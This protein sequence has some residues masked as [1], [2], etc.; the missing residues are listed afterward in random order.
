MS[1]AQ[2]FFLVITIAAPLWY[3]GFALH[4]LAEAIRDGEPKNPYTPSE[5]D[6]PRH[7]LYGTRLP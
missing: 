2:T 3:I 1:H 4:D 5:L 7:W 6:K